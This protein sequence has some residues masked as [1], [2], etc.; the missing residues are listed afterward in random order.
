MLLNSVT[1]Q[2]PRNLQIGVHDAA[3]RRAGVA[4]AGKERYRRAAEQRSEGL[5]KRSGRPRDRAG[6]PSGSG[7]DQCRVRGPHGARHAARCLP[8]TAVS[9][10]VELRWWRWPRVDRRRAR[11][12]RPGGGISARWHRARSARRA[13]RQARSA[14]MAGARS[15]AW[16]R[17]RIAVARRPPSRARGRQRRAHGSVEHRD[18]VGRLILT[19]VTAPPSSTSS[20]I[21]APMASRPPTRGAPTRRPGGGFPPGAER[22]RFA[23]GP[24]RPASPRGTRAL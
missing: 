18:R 16:I 2:P 22:R 13:Q 6:D 11:H 9:T 4:T 1:P 24:R 20:R 8:R 19:R 17:W 12:L 23:T 21:R 15:L 3:D 14:A 5:G 10:C 7:G